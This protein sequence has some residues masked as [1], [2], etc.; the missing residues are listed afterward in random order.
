MHRFLAEKDRKRSSSSIRSSSQGDQ[1]YQD[2]RYATVLETHGIFMKEYRGRLPE[3]AVKF[4]DEI[5]E[6]LEKKQEVPRDSLFS[7]DSFEDTME[8]IQDRNKAFIIETISQLM[9]PHV[10][11]MAVRGAKNLRP[12]IQSFDEG[13]NSCKKITQTRPKPDSAIGFRA[14]EF[15]AAQL[16]KL[17]PYLGDLD[18]KSDFKATF[19]MYFPFL[20]YEVKHGNAGLDIADRQNAHSMTI[21]VRGLVALFR[22]AKKEQEIHGKILTMSFSFN[23]RMVRIYGYLPIIK[24][25]DTEVWREEIDAFDFRTRKGKDKWKCLQYSLNALDI[26]LQLLEWIRAAIDGWTPD[27][28]LEALRPYDT[29]FPRTVAT[30][31]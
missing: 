18:A 29:E 20:T 7:D 12:F 31:L 30:I 10:Q 26:G 16:E 27:P 24:G 21:A 1:G 15:S 13:W 22:L 2:A 8:M 28:E 17:Q 5:R 6:V 14:S 4:N 9:F 19:Y 11:A 3:E 25:Q 23:H